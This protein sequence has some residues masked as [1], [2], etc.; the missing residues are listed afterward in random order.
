MRLRTAHDVA[1]DRAF[2]WLPPSAP[3][4]T[5]DELYAHLGFDPNAS[6]GL[7][8]DPHYALF[9]N[10]YYSSYWVER[11][12]PKLLADV[13]AGSYRIVRTNDGIQLF[14]KTVRGEPPH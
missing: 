3:V 11:V 14:A 13:A 7:R 8:R 4:G 6:L 5:H 2:E 1:I 12:Q 9:D 10:T